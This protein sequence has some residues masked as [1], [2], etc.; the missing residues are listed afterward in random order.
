VGGRRC[1]PPG[2]R[3][4]ARC[5][6]RI[7]WRHLVADDWDDMSVEDKLEALRSAV[8]TLERRQDELL[9]HLSELADAV[10]AI[11]LKLRQ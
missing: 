2:T 3:G 5:E 10:A 7:A 11:E 4:I 8:S 6:P 9:R 1:E